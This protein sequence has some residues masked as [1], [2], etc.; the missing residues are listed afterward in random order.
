MDSILLR[1]MAEELKR[2]QRQ[3]QTGQ[4]EVATSNSLGLE[5]KEHSIPF[6]DVLK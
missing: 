6:Q 2:D 1:E 4:F 3:Q 5:D